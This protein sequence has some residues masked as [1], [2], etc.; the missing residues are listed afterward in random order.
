MN[1][2]TSALYA[3][4]P[5]VTRTVGDDAFDAEGNLV[6]YDAAAVETKAS[7]MQ[8]QANRAAAYTLESDPVF[9]KYQRGEALETEWI[10]KVDEIR[11]RFPYPTV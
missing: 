10:A 7:Q 4:Y 8:A 11:A 2:F 1:Y 3:L 9:F 6:S 5:N